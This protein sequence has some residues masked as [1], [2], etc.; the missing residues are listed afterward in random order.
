M[1]ATRAKVTHQELSLRSPS[2]ISLY[3]EDG[4]AGSKRLSHAGSLDSLIGAAT[5]LEEGN[6]SS[7]ARDLVRYISEKLLSCNHGYQ[8]IYLLVG[9]HLAPPTGHLK[10]CW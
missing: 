5:S 1:A 8:F 3:G 9:V 4:M 2:I 10:R 7:V 6:L